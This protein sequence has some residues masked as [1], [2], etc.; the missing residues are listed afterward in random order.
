[1]HTVK[2]EQIIAETHD[3]DEPIFVFRAKDL[4]SLLALKKYQEVTEAYSGDDHEFAE[5]VAHKIHDFIDW[6]R[7]NSD[8]V[9][10][11]D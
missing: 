10:L 7:A 8:K 6:Q 9:K 5:G 11:P 1:M 3:T 2:D 4:L